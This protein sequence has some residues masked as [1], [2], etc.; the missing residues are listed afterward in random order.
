MKP[1]TPTGCTYCDSGKTGLH[2]HTPDAHQ[3]KL[4]T[5]DDIDFQTPEPEGESKQFPWG[6]PI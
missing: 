5:I 2:K 3:P 1:K 6:L 4:P